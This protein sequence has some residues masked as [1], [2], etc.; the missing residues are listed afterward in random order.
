MLLWNGRTKVMIPPFTNSAAVRVSRVIWNC[1]VSWGG[2]LGEG[3]VAPCAWLLADEDGWG[4]GRFTSLGLM[5]TTMRKG[6]DLRTEA[7]LGCR[8]SQEPIIVWLLTPCSETL[9]QWLGVGHGG[10]VYTIKTDKRY[11]SWRFPGKIVHISIPLALGNSMV[12]VLG[13]YDFGEELVSEE[14]STGSFSQTGVG[15]WKLHYACKSWWCRSL[16]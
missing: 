6:Q 7:G 12:R 10:S 5:Q 4:F 16:G 1:G 8:G 15:Y 2:F 3:D 11:K 14:P 9:H 13:V